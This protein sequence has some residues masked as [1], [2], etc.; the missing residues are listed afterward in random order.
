M[1]RKRLVAAAVLIV[2]VLAYLRDPPWLGDVTSGMLPWEDDPPGTRFRWTA[3]RGSFF[4]SSDATAMTLPLRAVFP[5]PNG[6]PVIVSVSVDD[7]WLADI[8]LPRPDEW[9][10]PSLPLPRTATSRRFRR[11]DL[12]VSRTAVGPFILGVMTGQIRL[13]R[14]ARFRS[15]RDFSPASAA[16]PGR[17]E[18]LRYAR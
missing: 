8:E 4:V 10:R 16:R 2:C 12:H 3:G 9:V 18:D 5:G 17:S 11:V 6:R 13:E 15:P 7:R 14:P 1:T